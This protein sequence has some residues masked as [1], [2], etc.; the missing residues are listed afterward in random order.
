[1]AM[2]LK[3]QREHHATLSLSKSFMWVKVVGL[4]EP[5]VQKLSSERCPTPDACLKAKEGRSEEKVCLASKSLNDLADCFHR[6][7]RTRKAPASQR[8]PQTQVYLHADTTQLWQGHNST[9]LS[10]QRNRPFPSK[11]PR[12]LGHELEK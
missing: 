7:Q 12:F 1:M 10:K 6:S 4:E 2:F 5:A 11:R 9:V 8:N 3:D